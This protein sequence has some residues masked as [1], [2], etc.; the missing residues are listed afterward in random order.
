MAEEKATK[1]KK[2]KSSL[3]G[4]QA[5]PTVLDSTTKLDIDTNKVLMDNI[6][7]AGLNSTLD[8]AAL[9]H[10]TSISNSRDQIYQLIDTMCQDSAVSSIV[11]TY[12]EDVCEPADSG[13]VVWCES[14]DPNISK[15]V[16]YLLNVINVDKNIF[17]WVYCLIK[18]GDVYLRL[19]RE[20]DYDD[21]MFKKESRT[22]LNE[23]L[24]KTEENKLDEAVKISLHSAN[25]QYS[26]YVEM[27][28]DPGTMFEL[29]KFGQTYGY[30]EVPN[31]PTPIDQST[32]VGGTTGLMS[33]NPFAFNYKSGDVIIHQ[34]D[35]FVHAC[36]EDNISRTPETVDLFYE[37]PTVKGTGVNRS[38]KVRRG[39][40][41][42]YDAYKVWRE[43]ALL[44]SAVLLSRITRSGIVRKVSVEVGD[45]PKEQVQ[46]T[47]R[48][49]K[50]LFEQKSAIN[51]GQSFSE[52]NNPGAVENFIYH[53]THDGKGAI[54]VESV[55]GDFDPKQ[56]T[57]LDWWNNKFYSSFG[58]PKQYFGWCFSKDTEILLLN[59]KKLTLEELYVNKDLY[60]GK[61]IMACN[62][63][64][65][66][67]P[68]KIKNIMQTS[69]NAD[70]VRVWLDNGK[71]VDVTPDHRMMLRDGTFIEAA[72]LTSGDS[73]MPYYDKIKEGRRYILDN[74]LGKFVP[75]Y[76]LVAA[77][78]GEAPEVGYNIHHKNRIKIDDDFDNLIKIP[79]EDHCKEHNLDLAAA[80]KAANDKRRQSGQ[81]VNGNVGSKE[82][83]NGE[84]WIRVKAGED[85]PDGFWFAGH[86]KS[87]ETRAKISLAHK[88]KAKNYDNTSH[89]NTPEV[90][91][92]SLAARQAT[93]D[94]QTGRKKFLTRCPNCGKISST[95]ITPAEY[96]K[97]LNSE[98]FYYC[99]PA[100]RAALDYN[101]KLEAS[102]QLYTGNNQDL[103]AY[104]TARRALGPVGSKYFTKASLT[105][106]LYTLTDYVP[107]VNHQVTKVEH[108]SSGNTVYDLT[109]EA[110]CHT[111]ALPCGIFVHNCDDGAGF[112]GG[113]SLTIISSV[114]AKG[115]KRIQN[116]IL[117][118]ITD[119]I[120][121]ILL[122]K[123]CKAY[124]NNFVLKMQTPVTQEEI[125]RRENL[126]NRANAISSINS[127]FSD[128]E[129]KARR[130]AILK[131]L[132][133]P[134]H[135][136]DEVMDIIQKEVE[137]A[138]EAARK[139]KEAEEAEAKAKAEEASGD[140][141]LDLSSI[142]EIGA[143]DTADDIEL[144]PMPDAELAEES[145]KTD[146]SK[147]ILVEDGVLIED[148]DDL[149]TPE[150]ADMG[151]DFT[152]N[153]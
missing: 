22:T 138:E 72:N 93:Y 149:P 4:N 68:T 64:G 135:L 11:R 18:Y 86:P 41:L 30:I 111:F 97:Y 59:G 5:K 106:K 124:L 101:G 61:G 67:C 19:Y 120:N 32:Y 131:S 40:S 57:D 48:R 100:C 45:M 53:A 49:V 37:D 75:Q 110:D 89:L 26:Y 151:R 31:N 87:G 83:T 113:S 91:A 56:L 92:K 139:A 127:L 62:T 71:Y 54:T 114:Y 16:N 74:K 123:G 84:Y 14:Q 150:E 43:K 96:S 69:T 133:A 105:D 25:D 116:T 60:I 29:T 6:I 85:L 46:Q 115:V 15:F 128:I 77:A 129:D 130:L 3:I 136:G 94:L 146:E 144:A 34:A 13:H 88:G 7:E 39:K 140:M 21:P 42:L 143:E 9:E 126:N 28:P 8:T 152:E 55:G 117:Q 145:F 23:E 17:S 122:N 52:Y 134:L 35:D 51:N 102:L 36:L 121:L 1:P 153:L 112:N 141:D 80:H 76:H 24:Q 78:K 109:V 95:K 2:P 20:S 147:T 79:T 98:K 108:L 103:D 65:S 107:E 10:F 70:L 90:Q 58:M 125:D 82:A 63:D 12:T 27:V 38:Y 44:E 104:E 119:I 66:L 142:D 73:L 148:A 137:A 47:L 118:A 33:S 81:A 99:S 50:E 132:V